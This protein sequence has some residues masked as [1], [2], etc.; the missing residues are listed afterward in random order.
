MIENFG[1]SLPFE[2]NIYT[3]GDIDLK[4]NIFSLEKNLFE[5]H[6]ELPFFS[7]NE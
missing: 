6:P 2:A 1:T 7:I 4:L 5:T 3:K